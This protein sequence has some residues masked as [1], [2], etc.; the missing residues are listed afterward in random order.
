MRKEFDFLEPDDIDQLLQQPIM[1]ATVPGE[2]HSV[3][4][5]LHDDTDGTNEGQL[6]VTVACD[7]DL[8]IKTTQT[9]EG[10]NMLRF[11]CPDGGGLSPRVHN[12]LRLLAWA[13]KLDNEQGPRRASDSVNE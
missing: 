10:S 3:F 7:N 6:V 9:H 1:A 8:W 12:A 4:T 13:I 11:R 2:Y 5:R